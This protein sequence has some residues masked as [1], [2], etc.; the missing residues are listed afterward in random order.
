MVIERLGRFNRV[1]RSGLNLLIPFVERPKTL[2]VRYLWK[3]FA[4]VHAP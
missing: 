3:V 1:A 2:D 4:A